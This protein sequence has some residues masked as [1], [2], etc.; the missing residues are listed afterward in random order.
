MTILLLTIT[1]KA[2][3]TEGRVIHRRPAFTS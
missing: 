3:F 2:L 1:D